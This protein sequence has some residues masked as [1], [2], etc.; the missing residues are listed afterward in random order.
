MKSTVENFIASGFIILTLITFCS[1]TLQAASVQDN[2]VI[3]VI[4]SNQG[5]PSDDV[6]N[7]F[8]DS[9]GFLWFCTTEG[10][11]R[12]DG[13]VLKTFSI[14]SHHNKGLI[15]N[16][17][18]AI[19]EDS[20]GFLWC[21]TDRG[22]AR[23]N[24]EMETFAFFNTHTQAPYALSYDV[25]NTLA[26]DKQN[27]IWIGSSGAGVEVLDPKKGIIARY[28]TSQ[29]S[30][31]MNSDWITHIA[32]D[33]LNNIWICS[34]Q[35][36][37]T[38]VDQTHNFIKS[39]TK[40]D[41]PLKLNYF[42]PFSM[43]QN[44][45]NEYWLGLWGEGIIYLSL[46][47]D[48]LIVK[49]HLDLR[50]QE[51]MEA[52]N[53][54]F[55][56]TFD[57]D[58]NLWVG[59]ATG[60]FRIENPK[61]S[62]SAFL[63][64]NTESRNH[65]ISNNEA[66]TVLCDASGLIWLGTS[67]GGINKI[68]NKIKMFKTSYINN[69]S[70][71][72]LSQSVTAFIK[73]PEDDLL[74]GV[75]SHGFGKYNLKNQ[76][77]TKFTQLPGFDHLPADLNTVNCFLWDSKGFLWLGTRYMGI[78][79]VNPK[80]GK[81]LIIN[82]TATQYN[83]P[84]REI[85]DIQEDSFG[86]IWVG[87]ENGLYKIIASEPANF[88]NFIILRYASEDGNYES[89]SSNRISKILIDHNHHLWI[90]TFDGG[91]NLSTSDIR[92]HYPLLFER[93]QSAQKDSNNLITDHILTLFEDTSHNLWVGSGGGGLFKW[94]PK[95]RKFSSCSS[96]VAGDIIY[97]INQDNQNNL[98]IGTN[99]GLT[100]M[101]LSTHE[102][103][104]NYFLRENGLQG[105]IFNKGASFKDN[106]G[107]LYFGGNNGFNYFN[108]IDLKPNNFIPPV[109]ITDVKVM[110]KPVI[111]TTTS[112]QPLVLNH[113]N[114]NFSVT[115]A[116]LS[117]SQP[118]NN[119]YAVRLEGLEEDWR[120]I[121]AD[122]R[123]LNY[124]N[125]KPGKYTLKIKGS[126]SQG[127][128]NQTPE[129]L[130][131]KVKPAPYKTWWAFSIYLFIFGAFILLIFRIEKKSQ[132]VKQDLEIEHIERQKSDKLNLF[133][134]GLFANISHEFLTPLNI[135]ACLIDVW[136]DE[137]KAPNSKDLALAERNINRLNRLN[138]QFLYYSQSEAKQLTLSVGAENLNKFTQN[139]CDN[140]IPLARKNQITFNCEINCPESN[141]WFDQEKLDIILYNLLSNAFKFTPKGETISIDLNLSKSEN[142]TL[143]HFTIKDTGKGIEPDQLAKIFDRYHSVNRN[144]QKTGGF[145]I[146][147]ALTKSMIETHKGS[148]DL[149]SKSGEGTDISFS[150]PINKNAYDKS[151][152]AENR[153]NQ[154]PIALL[155]PDDGDEEE[156]I[157]RIKNLQQSF[158]DKP[159]ILIVEDNADFRKLL[160][161]SLE[162]L[163][164]VIEAPNGII[165][166]ETARNKRPNLIISDVIMPSM[167]GIEL[168][169]KIKKN[170]T[171]SR[172]NVI[173]L[174]AK[175]SDE[176]RAEGY[177]AG[178][179]SYITKP[180][181]MNILLARIEA[182]LEQQKK[183]K[184]RI[185]DFDHNENKKQNDFMAS[186]RQIIEK[187]LSNPDFSV[188]TLAE[189][190]SISNSML[191]R[192]TSELLNI[193][194][195]TFIRKIKM[196]KAADMLEE[197][198]LSI[199][200]VAFKCG[201]KDVSYFGTSFKK[202][203]GLTPSQY[204]KKNNKI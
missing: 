51:S 25:I 102:I 4:S 53:I 5:L 196:M 6:K 42:S 70:E 118:E 155:K 202:N 203:Y 199:S 87:T 81:Y 72:L 41:I 162:P 193:N 172:I 187:N 39:W 134:Q 121:D 178:A 137:R 161:S 144:Y 91:V 198:N 151:E 23:L 12:Y 28:N 129:Q 153:Q 156:V 158:E 122:M 125:L 88:N 98:W 173:L 11:I 97:T 141:L 200:E 165:G 48:S 43:T 27:H 123:F 126:N 52:S 188:K 152:I 167:N 9:E 106:Q 109:V 38:L 78:I 92:N 124:A 136:R 107:G 147:L 164:S 69:D 116:A 74:I 95:Q 94:A 150:I 114:N 104:S 184:T 18:N 76:T 34:W 49:K 83:F 86:N 138:R 111:T 56:L 195:N 21:A 143:A 189:E 201:F 180:F 26:V 61:H 17:F 197:N 135:L 75:K 183:D 181:S 29:S 100:K 58:S 103:R 20:E 148:I 47:G 16:S 176:E 54:I 157:L 67:G 89:L 132:K 169:R 33:N 93:F 22:V 68:D 115:F 112:E 13:Y 159:V 82:K 55:D 177:R 120:I 73:T 60:L 44:G 185:K 31:G 108:P 84:S 142:Q 139:I 96:S 146:G 99:R 50:Q 140:F 37:L 63:Q 166:Y 45:D 7:V 179:D 110:N 66:Y 1:K 105:N 19:D 85:S 191:Y 62:D 119:K 8:Q 71:Q 40:S 57:Q 77:F 24:R 192:K 117:Y 101:N 186:A 154:M 128:W 79:K 14:S 204:Q 163:F 2:Y 175:I 131:I 30:T 65:R 3:N 160:K 35:G 64:F 149:K 194:P 46:E 32:K 59:S 145:G 170:E 168:C 36:A 113:L 10:L 133:K 130:F 15:T 174:T 80:T 127:Q 171:T 90:A 182:L 190:L